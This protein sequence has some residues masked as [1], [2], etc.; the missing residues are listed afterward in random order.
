M[1][2]TT[3]KI[4]EHHAQ[5]AQHHEKAAEHHKEASKHYEAGAV[6][7]GA[8]WR[9]FVASILAAP[10]MVNQSCDGFGPYQLL[11]WMP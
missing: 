11:F 4:A 10:V 7:K 2:A 9:I 5:A 3:T 8:Q 1:A 6:E